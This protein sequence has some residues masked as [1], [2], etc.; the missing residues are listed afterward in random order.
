[1]RKKHSSCAN[2]LAS[3]SVFTSPRTITQIWEISTNRSSSICY[4]RRSI[5]AIGFLTTTFAAYTARS[6][7]MTMRCPKEC[8]RL[9]F[10]FMIRCHTRHWRVFTWRLTGLRKGRLSAI[11]NI[12]NG[13]GDV[14]AHNIL[15]TVAAIQ[16]SP[17]VMEAQIAWGRG[18]PEELF[19]LLLVSEHASLSGKRSESS[20]L[21]QRAR[22]LAGRQKLTQIA[23]LSEAIEASRLAE[24]GFLAEAH[25]LAMRSA[26]KDEGLNVQSLAADVLVGDWR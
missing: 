3:A 20:L 9:S 23:A 14:V 1:M 22:E 11:G 21:A 7:R 13:M 6:V 8:V 24:F 19:Q 12:S 17:D 25:A 2:A 5:R 16:N 15:Y 10:S 26:A 4:G 18:Q